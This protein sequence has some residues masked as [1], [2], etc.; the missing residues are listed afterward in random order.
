MVGTVA[1]ARTIAPPRSLMTDEW[2]TA[3]LIASSND[4]SHGAG[5]VR[6]SLMLFGGSGIVAGSEAVIVSDV[7]DLSAVASSI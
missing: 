7:G 3:I 6:P 2:A 4:R 1:G 5:R